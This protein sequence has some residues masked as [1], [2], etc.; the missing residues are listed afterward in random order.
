M[1]DGVDS[2]SDDAGVGALE[3]EGVWKS[4]WTGK[5]NS[6]SRRWKVASMLRTSSSDL[7]TSAEVALAVDGV[8]AVVG[9]AALALPLLEDVAGDGIER[10]A[11]K[12]GRATNLC[13]PAR[14]R[15]QMEG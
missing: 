2:V 3:L 8:G 5:T 9:S 13:R 4:S 10:G 1:K 15:A 14:T 6:D 7:E 11:D 12:D